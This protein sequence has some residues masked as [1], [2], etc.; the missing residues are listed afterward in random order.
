MTVTVISV[1]DNLLPYSTCVNISVL[2]K[3]MTLFVIKK[4]IVQHLINAVLL[5]DSFFSDKI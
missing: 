3:N 4:N 2:L 5:Y 1:T